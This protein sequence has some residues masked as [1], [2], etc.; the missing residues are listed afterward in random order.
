LTNTPVLLQNKPSDMGK[1]SDKFISDIQAKLDSVNQH[2]AAF[3]VLK[4]QFIKMTD[5]NI[6]LIGDR[7]EILNGKY[8]GDEKKAKLDPAYIKLGQQADLVETNT[9]AMFNTMENHLKAI[10]NA[11]ADAMFLL[12]KFETFVNEKDK[13]TKMPWNKKSI[14]SSKTYIAETRAAIK[15]YKPP[16]FRL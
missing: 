5:D 4:P 9:G 15:A 10:T 3:L 11:C 7:V 12:T 16:E 13:T 14:G 8:K 2:A 6:D 1:T